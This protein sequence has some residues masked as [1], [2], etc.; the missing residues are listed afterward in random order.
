MS[1]L[2]RSVALAALVAVNGL[3]SVA[4]GQVTID[5]TRDA[6]YG[7]ATTVQTV[8]TQFGDNQ[9][10]LNA[11]YFNYNSSTNRIN[12]LLTGN[13][14][15]NNNKVV[16]FLDTQAGGQNTL[17]NDNPQVNFDQLNRRYGQQEIQNA[18]VLNPTGGPNA[19]GIAGPGFTFDA[20][21]NADYFLSFNR[22]NDAGGTLFS[23]YAELRTTGGGVGGF[24][25]SILAPNLGTGTGTIGGTNGL[26]SIDI[27]YNDTNA[28]GVIGGTTAADQ[29]AAAAVTTGL[30]FSIDA[31]AFDITGDFKILA[32]VNG[33]NH[34][35][36]SNQ[37]LPGFAAP[38]SNLGSD[39]LGNFVSL[40]TNADASDRGGTSA[41]VNLANFTGNQFVTVPISVPTF[42]YNVNANG[43]IS[44]PANFTPNGVPTGGNGRVLFGSVITAARTVTIDQDVSL[45]SLSFDNANTYTLAGANTISIIGSPATPAVRVLSGSHVISAPLTLT[46]DTRFDVATNSGLSITGTLNASGKNLFK[47][48]AGTL[49]LPSVAGAGLALNSITVNAG[50]LKT[51]LSGNTVVRGVTVDTGAT[52]DLQNGAVIV[53][54]DDT[55]SPLAAIKA[56]IIANRIT[57]STRTGNVAVGY[58]DTAFVTGVT[59]YNGAPLDANALVFRSTLKGDA[60][61]NLTVEFQDLVALAQNYNGTAKEWYQGDFDLDGDVDFQ[62]LIPLAQNYNGSLPGVV[63]ELGTAEFAADW[64][65][66]QSLVPE[67]T[68]LAALGVLG[69][70]LKRRRF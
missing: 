69:A 32:F 61:L 53:D 19:N 9:S 43:N 8:N 13:I 37:I 16:F 12:I 67:P 68:S 48:G 65:L 56:S 17:R 44:N 27:G 41:Y 39:G 46:V 38:Q 23:D 62:D 30:E 47:Q 45:I 15:S 34:D 54:Y 22:N 52:L 35:F 42:T 70:I 24:L 55:F 5:G 63:D 21:F 18:G 49:S 59:S 60:N 11:F 66:A 7:A 14:E 50:T 10:E 51:G 26:P 25:G 3:A 1:K 2:N 57:S 28:L 58:I 31:S 6:G 4:L 20:G 40:G 29:T 36:V 33:Q 64:A